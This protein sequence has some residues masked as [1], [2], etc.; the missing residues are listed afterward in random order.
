[1]CGIA[2]IA[3][4][5]GQ[6][7][8]PALLLAMNRAIAHRGPDD[9]GYVL[10]DQTSS[11]F[12]HYSGA[13]SPAD[14]QS[15]I[16]LLHPDEPSRNFNIGLCHRRFSIID[17]SSAG[18]QPFFDSEQR[19]C[20]VFNGEIYN[21]VELR[22][23]LIAKGAKFRTYSDTE[24]LVEAYKHWGVECFAK[25]NGFWALALYDFSTRQLLLSRD[26]IGK[27]P[28]YWT[29]LGSRVYFASEIKALLQIPDVSRR[30]RVSEEAV[31]DW[32]VYGQRDLNFGTFFEGI[33]AL[34]PGSWSAVN[35]TFP[36]QHRAFWSVPSERL[37]E[38][39][40]S[41]PE[42]CRR[43]RQICQDAVQ[44]RLRCDVPLALELSGGLDSSVVLALSAQASPRKL[45]SYTIRFP[46]EEHNEEPFARAVAQ[47]YDVDYRV[48]DSPIDNFWCDILPFTYLQEEPYHMPNMHTSQVIW[49]HMRAAGTKVLLSGSGGD[50]NFAG[51]NIY[52]DCHQRD[53]ISSGRLGRYLT[54]ALLNTESTG[55]WRSLSAPL[56]AMVR[57]GIRR[58]APGQLIDKF[59]KDYWPY[60]RS[61]RYW[62]TEPTTAAQ[63]LHDYM[64]NLLM[65]YWLSSG[66][67]VVMGM[68][69]EARSP[70]LDYRV[71]ELAFRL[72]TSYLIRNGWRKWI[73]RKAME[74]LLPENVVWR[75]K[76]MG[77]PF[78]Y[79]RFR[80]DSRSI[81][82]RILTNAK[83]P[84]LDLSQEEALEQNW[85]TM[86]FVIW[87]ELYINGNA[88]LLLSLQDTALQEREK[89]EYGYVP[90]YLRTCDLD[91]VRRGLKDAS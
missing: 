87:H 10:I 20:A 40:I 23:E 44:L 88:D 27:K 54:N 16:P 75:K 72:P 65:P 51:Y 3:H 60:Y 11:R 15:N 25:L 59:R 64:T 2:G 8:Q 76:K 57:T 36:N 89:S 14:V 79:D 52:F 69:I 30:R 56:I 82:E 86:S 5:D 37:R 67:K 32:L 34:P 26:R 73:L 29:K 47:R 9:E 31:S 18:H 42:A 55:R 81:M 43:L 68:P 85:K 50:E 84:F 46:D 78:P 74:D 21:Y 61:K 83:N 66:D 6:P 41:V 1:M 90:E 49:S 91:A 71:I 48:L 62:K 22:D 4:L 80:N 7:V 77:F 53:N 38:K 24:V 39:D 19:C 28:L 17:L 58:H 35:D 45:T 33:H 13:S 12:A 63:A 70:F